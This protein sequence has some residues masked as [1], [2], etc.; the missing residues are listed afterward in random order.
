MLA[1]THKQ[2]FMTIAHCCFSRIIKQWNASIH[3]SKTLQHQISW[4][5]VQRFS[6]C[7]MSSDG[8]LDLASWRRTATVLW[9]NSCN[10]VGSHRLNYCWPS[11]AQSFLVP[12][13]AGL[14]KIFYCLMTLGDV[15]RR[16]TK[17]TYRHNHSR[18]GYGC[19]ATGPVMEWNG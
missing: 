15:K 19:L 13:T 16:A 7:Y 10:K 1:Y 17:Q 5:S 6:R 4:K 12:I 11:P 9:N 8:R 18:T 2:D 3:F 14:V